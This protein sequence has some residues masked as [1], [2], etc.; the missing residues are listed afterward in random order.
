MRSLLVL[1][2]LI[3]S[4]QAFTTTTQGPWKQSTTQLYGGARGAATSP[5]GKQATVERVKELLDSSEM[6]FSIPAGSMT[7]QE[8]QTLRAGLPETTTLKVVKNTLLKRAV[9]GTDYEQAAEGLL[10]GP[11]AW[12]FIEEDISGTIKAYNSFVK[13]FDKKESHQILGGIMEGQAYDTAGV[14]AIGK[15]PSKQELYAKIAGSIKAVPTKV[16]RVIKAPS[17]KLARAIQLATAE[18]KE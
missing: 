6:V 11:N 7:V 17:S 15:L 8:T 10:K 13:E 5:A 1:L 12:F 9:E 14:T 18:D 2:S 4:S 3:S 16:A